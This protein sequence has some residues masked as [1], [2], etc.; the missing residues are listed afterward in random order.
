MDAPMM[1]IKIEDRIRYYVDSHD[2]K[3]E[4]ELL[5]LGYK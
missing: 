5:A 2:Y 4:K 3:Y 1:V